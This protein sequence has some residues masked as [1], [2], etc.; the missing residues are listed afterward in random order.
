[1]KKKIIASLNTDLIYKFLKDNNLTKSG[2]CKKY[3]FSLSSLNNILKCNANICFSKIFKLT[4]FLQ[5]ELK[6]IFIK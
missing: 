2:F 5:I 6:D 4:K 1:M 3:N